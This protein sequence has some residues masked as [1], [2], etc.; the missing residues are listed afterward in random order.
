MTGVPWIPNS[1][2]PYIETGLVGHG[3]GGDA[4]RRVQEVHLPERRRIGAQVIVGVE[5]VDAVVL[6][7]YIDYVVS[8]VERWY[9]NVGNV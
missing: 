1:V 5:G 8:S 7:S 9:E 2:Y 3:N 4:I 6:C